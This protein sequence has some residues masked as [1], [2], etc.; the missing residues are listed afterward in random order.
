[1]EEIPED[2]GDLI[3]V[4]NIKKLVGVMSHD[5]S[6]GTPVIIGDQLW[7]PTS[8][9]SGIKY[10]PARLDRHVFE[11]KKEEGTLR[12][13]SGGPN[14]L[15]LDKHTGQ[16]IAHD[17]LKIERIFHGQW[18][19]PC[20]GE[21][22]GEQVVFWG[23]GYGYLHAFAVP[24]QDLEP[25]ENPRREP[26][27]HLEVLWSLDC[28]PHRY[29]YDESGEEFHYPFHGEAKPFERPGVGIGPGEVIATPVFYDGLVYIA[30]GRDRAYSRQDDEI[31][32]GSLLCIDPG[33]VDEDGNPKIVWRTEKLHR[34]QSTVSIQDGLI[35]VADMGGLLNCFDQE[36]GEKVWE[37]DLGYMVEC[38]SQFVADGKIYVA[39]DKRDFYIFRTGREPEVVFQTKVKDAIATPGA[40]DGVLFIGSP[41]GLS[42]YYG[43]GYD[44]PKP[45]VEA[46]D[47]AADDEADTE[48]VV[49]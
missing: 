42:A 7:V 23:D 47:D 5:S 45:V 8:N 34:T 28:N 49:D 12:P 1:M 26:A 38:R 31:Y 6:C 27:P 9:C 22:D 15:V 13:G 29:R 19:S 37:Y 14:M 3:W 36:T 18:S 2:V 46:T 48:P 30:I 43:P 17:P 41:R 25:I 39:T 10:A 24:S 40:V 11:K 4:S 33:E 44:G 21:V 32:N 35:Y 16:M 20:A